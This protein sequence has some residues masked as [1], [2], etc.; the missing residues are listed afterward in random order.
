M[1]T[2]PK[3]TPWFV[4][5]EKPARVGVYEVGED[6]HRRWFQHWNGRW[7]GYFDTNPK[8]AQRFG[9]RQ[10]MYQNFRWRGLASKP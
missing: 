10:S 9:R 3:M 7:W 5:G 4:N 8:D 2:E 6:G 1:S